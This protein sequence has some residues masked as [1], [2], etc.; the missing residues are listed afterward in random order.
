MTPFC[1]PWSVHWQAAD[2][3]KAGF[4]ESISGLD[5]DFRDPDGKVTRVRVFELRAH[6]RGQIDFAI[7]VEEEVWVEAPS[8]V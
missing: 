5:I 3:E 6:G 4:S 1:Q 8:S 7:V 2:V